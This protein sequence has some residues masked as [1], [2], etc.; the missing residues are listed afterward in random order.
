MAAAYLATYGEP[1]ACWSEQIPGRFAHAVVIPAYGEGDNLHAMLRTLQPVTGPVCAIVVLNAT[2]AAPAWAHAANTRLW[3]SF[4]QGASTL[5]AASVP[6]LLLRDMPFGLLVVVGRH[7]PDHCLPAGN[8]VGLARKIGGDLAL[9]LHLR[10]AISGGWLH[11]TD[12]DVLLPADYLAHVDDA[13]PDAVAACHAFTHHLADNPVLAEAAHT[14]EVSL[15]Y[16]VLGLRHAKSPY[17]YHT[18]GSTIA[19]RFGTYVKVRGMA[20]RLAAE[21]FYFLD[22]VRKTGRIAAIGRTP[23]QL[24]RTHLAARAVWHGQSSVAACYR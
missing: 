13:P 20:K 12:A 6:P 19:V 11:Y 8:G 21:D 22:K 14:Y 4:A 23:L 15:R 3:N 1:D 18:I 5:T 10:G 9:A 7:V 24:S 2:A 17:A 16:L